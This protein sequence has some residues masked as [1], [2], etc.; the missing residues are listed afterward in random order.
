LGTFQLGLTNII[1]GERALPRT[2]TSQESHDI[3]N[4]VFW[5]FWKGKKKTKDGRT[6]KKR[7]DSGEKNE[8]FGIQGEEE[9]QQR[10]KI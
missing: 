10:K 9:D 1:K 8:H 4:F 3:S 2:R 7:P 6:R 5:F